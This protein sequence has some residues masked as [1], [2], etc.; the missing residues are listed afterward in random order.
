MKQNLPVPKL[1]LFNRDVDAFIVRLEYDDIA[2]VN[3]LVTSDFHIP[4]C[5]IC[6]RHDVIVKRITSRY[7]DP[8]QLLKTHQVRLTGIDLFGGQVDVKK[9][10]E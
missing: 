8:Y 6:D 2:K 1:I 9:L 4:E 7:S 3:V 10:V 5:E